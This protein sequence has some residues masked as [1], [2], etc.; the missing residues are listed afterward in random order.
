MCFVFFCLLRVVPGTETDSGP[1]LVRL[2]GCGPRRRRHHSSSVKQ[3]KGRKNNES[4]GRGKDTG[5][6]FHPNLN[7]NKM[8]DRQADSKGNPSKREM[9]TLLR[10]PPPPPSHIMQRK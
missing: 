3:G 7:E 10:S 5:Q 2:L 8:I 6:T 1:G 4:N 9:R